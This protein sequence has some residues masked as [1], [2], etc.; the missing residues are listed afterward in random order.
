MNKRQ[1]NIARNQLLLQKYL[2]EK[3]MLE[4]R[5]ARDSANAF[6]QASQLQDAANQSLAQQ[7]AFD[8]QRLAQITGPEGAILRAQAQQEA[9]KSDA[10]A[11]LMNPAIQKGRV[12]KYGGNSGRNPFAGFLSGGLI[13]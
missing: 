13:T 5:K 9:A 6:A 11:G 1:Y 10:Y 8:L 3:E 4:N 2:S 7:Q 12:N